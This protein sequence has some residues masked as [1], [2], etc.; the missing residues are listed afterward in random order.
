VNWRR[1]NNV[2]HRD[3]GYLAVG[4]SIVYGVS[5]LAVNHI[6]DWNPSFSVSRTTHAIEPLEATDRDGLVREALSKLGITAAPRNV[7]R[8]NPA[9]LQLFFREGSYSIDIETGRVTIEQARPRPVLFEMNQMHLNTPK[10]VWTIFADLYAVALVV[11]AF[12]GLFVLKGRTGITG[13]GAWL[14]GAGV[15]LPA[16]YWLYH[17]FLE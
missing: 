9:T 8:P 14:T 5:G 17:L 2:L 4:L 15:L 16:G 12:T 6:R 10:K 13:R 11:L 3:I 7:F 1:L